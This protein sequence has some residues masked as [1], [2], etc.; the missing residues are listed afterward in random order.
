M[1]FCFGFANEQMWRSMNV[2]F[3]ARRKKK[4]RSQSLVENGSNAEAS[5][6]I[7]DVAAVA[8]V[9]DNVVVNADVGDEDV[10]GRPDALPLLLLLHLR[11]SSNLFCSSRWRISF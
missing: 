9:D 4:K 10:G 5:N 3:D 7:A 8:A 2:E 1:I 11:S 6:A